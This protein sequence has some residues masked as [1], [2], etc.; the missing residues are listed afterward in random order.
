MS[1]PRVLL[2]RRACW[3]AIDQIRRE[4]ASISGIPRQLGT[5]W[6]TVWVA[7][8]GVDEHVLHHVFERPIDVGG[9]GPKQLIGMVNLTP[10]VDGKP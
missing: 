1:A 5:T 2:T 10:D 6:N 7:R 9:R 4:N 3:W 8:P